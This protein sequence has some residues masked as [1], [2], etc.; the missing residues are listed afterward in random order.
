MLKQFFYG[1]NKIV[2]VVMFH[3]VGAENLDWIFNYI[4]EPSLDFESKISCLKKGGFNFITW[5]ELYAYMRGEIQLKQP[6]ILL[7]FDD[8]YL[9]NWVNVYPILKKYDAKGTIFVSSDF[10]DPSSECR[11]NTDDVAAGKCSSDQLED[12]GFLNWSE[13]REMEASGVMDI[14]S[15]AAS[16][17]WYFKND[18]VIDFWGPNAK[19]YPWMPWNENLLE[20]PFYMGESQY[21]MVKPGTPIYEFEKSLIVNKF[22]PSEAIANVMT[23]YV[24]EHGGNDYFTNSEWKQDLLDRHAVVS[25]EYSSES[26][27]ETAGERRARTY[28][29]LSDSKKILEDNLNKKIDFI[30]W[31]GGG[32]DQLTLDVARDAGFKS[33][34]L[35][36]TDSSNFRNVSCVNPENVKRIGSAIKQYWKGKDIGFTNGREFYYGVKRHQG[37]VYHKWAGRVLKAY[38]I[39]NSN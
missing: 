19:Q 31:P 5:T 36:S 34:T 8:G 23:T 13:M 17:T 14:Q 3:S 38:R 35:G 6:S 2:P 9:D 37:S 33:W 7:T 18:T 30:C 21:S 26:R 24:A 16:H 28:V 27:Y 4:S 22:I 32:Y 1:D 12:S 15:H 20:K 25:K 39:V 11:F 10:V 29:E